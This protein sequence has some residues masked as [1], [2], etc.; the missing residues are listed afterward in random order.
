MRFGRLLVAAVVAFGAL[1]SAPLA[2]GATSIGQVSYPGASGLDPSEV[3]SYSWGLSH[4]GSATSGGG[5]GSG[6]VSYQDLNYTAPI[7]GGTARLA[8][9]AATGKNLKDVKL[10][11]DSTAT[12]SLPLTYCLSNASVRKLT[13]SNIGSSGQDGVDVTLA[14]QRLTMAVSLDLGFTV[15]SFDLKTN[16]VDFGSSSSCPD[17]GTPGT[18]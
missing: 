10:S 4:S 16:H 12:G 8:Y 9:L 18:P 7:K 13:V 15:V 3:F 6:K 1:A 14:F 2:W 17:S 11:I 5:A